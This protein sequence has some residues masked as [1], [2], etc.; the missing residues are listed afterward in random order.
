MLF[1]LASSGQDCCV[2]LCGSHSSLG[3]SFPILSE[4]VPRL[5]APLYF[6]RPLG[7]CQSCVG[8]LPTWLVLQLITLTVS[9][10]Q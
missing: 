8:S 10:I 1:A 7:I 4:E 2:T 3:L 6:T 5:D 9:F